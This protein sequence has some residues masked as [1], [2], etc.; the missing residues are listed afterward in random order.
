MNLFKAV[1]PRICWIVALGSFLSGCGNAGGLPAQPGAAEAVLPGLTSGPRAMWLSR[2]IQRTKK[3]LFV[4]DTSTD[5]VYIYQLPKLALEGTLTGFKRPEGMC[6]D[7]DGN[8]WIT[9]TSASTITEFSHTGDK[10]ATVSDPYGQPYSC[11]FDP[12]TGN[13]AVPNWNG[14]SSLGNLAIFPAGS[15]QPSVITVPNQQTYLYAGYD[16][17]G[18][19]YFDGESEYFDYTLF[20]CPK[21]SSSCFQLTLN[22]SMSFP[23]LVQW[24]KRGNYLAVGNDGCSPTGACIYHVNVAGSSGTVVGTTDLETYANGKACGV[25]QGVIAQVNGKM[26]VMAGDYEPQGCGG[27]TT[28]VNIWRYGAGGK[29]WHHTADVTMPVG[30]AISSK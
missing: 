12:T 25:G 23:G 5:N 14:P 9:D 15:S 19:L 2:E 4:S 28:T 24:Y 22:A 13:M 20:E 18:N 10:L 21:G 17:K 29:P 6:T 8:V 3:L 1:A 11:A 30:V 26:S 16:P 27:A 7:K